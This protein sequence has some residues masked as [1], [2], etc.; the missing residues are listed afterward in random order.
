[1]ARFTCTVA[2]PHVDT[3]HLL[4]C[5]LHNI[6]YY[7]HP[8]IDVDVIVIDQSQPA[9]KA[10]VKAEFD[11]K[12]DA[13]GR[14]P[15]KVIDAPRLDAGYPLDVAVKEAT[16]EFFCSLDCDCWPITPSWLAIPIEQVHRYNLSFAGCDCDLHK[17]YPHLGPTPIINNF[18]RVSRTDLAHEASD[19]V[20]FMRPQHRAAAG[21][22]SEFPWP[23]QWHDNGVAANWYVANKYPEKKPLGIPVTRH[24]GNAHDRADCCVYGIIVGELVFHLGYGF[25]PDTVGD[26]VK[27]LGQKF[28]DLHE[29]FAHQENLV[30]Y[31]RELAE[32]SVKYAFV[33]W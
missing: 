3:P 12:S 14:T 6:L 19:R 16:G 20:G 29:S 15:I 22:P 9:I 31:A 1:M 33:G 8:D 30:A 7:S 13:N 24:L 23:T 18:F 21:M 2:V 26:A 4:R 28:L 32:R 10:A 5:C 11:G 17:A 25:H 27:Q